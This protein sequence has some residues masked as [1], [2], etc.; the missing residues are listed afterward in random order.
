M[1]RGLL[2]GRAVP[3]ARAILPLV[4]AATLASACAPRYVERE[5]GAEGG[6]DGGEVVVGT[7]DEEGVFRADTVAAGTADT[8]AVERE[9]VTTGTITPAEPAMATGYRVQVLADTDRADA[10]AFADRVG[11]SV[12]HPVYVE[13]SEPWWKVRVGDFL[14]RADA[15]RVRERLVA[16]GIEGAWT[17]RT[18]VRAG[19]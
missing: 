14:D 4:L 18:V 13:W 16:E 7:V 1:R 11:R 5:P 17:V 2:S 6:A 9:T 3:P 19:P 10:E 8:T 12:D 15:E